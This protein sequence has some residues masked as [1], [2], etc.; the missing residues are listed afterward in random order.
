MAQT[1]EQ[2]RTPTGMA[3]PIPFECGP[4]CERILRQTRVP[5]HAHQTRVD[6]AEFTHGEFEVRVP[7][8]GSC[9]YLRL[10]ANARE[11]LFTSSRIKPT[12]GSANMG[13]STGF[14]RT[15]SPFTT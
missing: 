7:M 15:S 14:H 9:A 12:K 2:P 11:R 10:E 1:G 4:R 5:T 6:P 8:Q 3:I 13:C